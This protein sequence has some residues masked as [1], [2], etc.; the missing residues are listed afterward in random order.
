MI[1]LFLVVWGV[2]SFIMNYSVLPVGLAS[3]PY[4]Y[5][6]QFFRWEWVDIL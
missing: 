4:A 5:S 3:F 1:I 6:C 2:D